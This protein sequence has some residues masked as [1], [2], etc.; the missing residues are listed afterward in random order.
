[1]KL[2]ENGVDANFD[3]CAYL[4]IMQNYCMQLMEYTKKNNLLD[5][6]QR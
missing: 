5:K 2:E 3:I 6:Y 4:Y 1:M